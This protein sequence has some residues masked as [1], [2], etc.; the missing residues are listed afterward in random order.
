MI[1]QEAQPHFALLGGALTLSSPTNPKRTGPRMQT[2]LIIGAGFSGTLTAVQLLRQKKPGEALQ[3]LLLERRSAAMARGLAYSTLCE[4]HILNVPAGNMSALPDDPDHF[5]RFCQRIDAATMPS[6]FVS[7][8]VYGDYLAWLLDQTES[9]HRGNT[10]LL[11]IC[12]EAARIEQLRHRSG[13][14][15]HLADGRS[16]EADRIV[17]ASGHEAPQDPPV[18]NARFYRSSRYVRDPWAATDIDAGE[19]RGATLLIGTGLTAVD[20]C[21]TLANRAPGGTVYALSRHGLLPQAHRFVRVA[22]PHD[23]LPQLNEDMRH[24]VR[25]LLRAIR[26]H[27]AARAQ[28]GDDWREV[29][30]ALRPHTHALWQNLRAAEKKCFLRHLRPY[31]DSHRHRVAPR[32]YALFRQSIGSGAVKI[33]AGRILDFREEEEGVQVIWRPRHQDK[34]AVLKVGRVINCTGPSSD[35]VR[36]GDTLTRQMMQEGLMCGDSLRLGLEVAENCA[37][38]DARGNSSKAMY[39]IGPLLK[40][41]YWEATAVPELR[42]FAQRLAQ[43]LLA[44][45]SA[46]DH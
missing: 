28:S 44:S 42:V 32:P 23:P 39:Y 46:R 22:L 2:I 40:A 34:S 6:S 31:W 15:I 16:F 37:L 30:A 8:R 17:L 25:K 3:I 35:L 33:L 5:L 4:E 14:R 41:R 18:K 1:R 19:P 13:A 36:T 10:S 21:A 24:S 9:Q 45:L 43:T 29:I 27:I 26:N 12:G 20:I 7:R 38:I 11:R